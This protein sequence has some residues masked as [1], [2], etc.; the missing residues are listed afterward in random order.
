MQLARLWRLRRSAGNRRNRIGSCS[1]VNR[2]MTLWNRMDLAQ[3]DRCQIGPVFL[4]RAGGKHAESVSAA[5]VVVKLRWMVCIHQRTEV[6]QRVLP[7]GAIVLGLQQ[8]RRRSKGVGRVDGIEFGLCWW[9]GKISRIDDDGEVGPSIDWRSALHGNI[10]RCGCAL[11]VV[12][13]RMRGHQHGEIASGGEADDADAIGVQMP[14]RSMSACDPHRLLRI[15]Q[16]RG[17]SRIVSR[18]AGRLRNTILDQKAGHAD[19]V[20]P[21][22]SVGAFGVPGEPNVAPAGKDQRSGPVAVTHRFVHRDRRNRDI[23]ESD[24]VMAI[25]ERIRRLGDVSLG[26]AGLRRFRSSVRPQWH[27]RLLSSSRREQ[28]R[29]DKRDDQQQEG[30]KQANS[31]PGSHAQ[32]SK[33]NRGVSAPV[34]IRQDAYFGAVTTLSC[35]HLA[36]HRTNEGLRSPLIHS[37]HGIGSATMF[38]D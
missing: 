7:E 1:G 14:L 16:V 8:E 4:R 25:G 19:R 38:A 33:P 24:S 21:L 31:R 9:N 20:Q 17:V 13:V 30:R 18:V 28:C 37:E 6:D 12:V 5:C 27:N 26:L 32:H 36:L 2:T 34:N 29:G 22:A 10:S 11:H 35:K 15:L 3:P 23:G